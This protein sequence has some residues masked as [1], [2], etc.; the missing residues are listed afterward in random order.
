[1]SILICFYV[2][3]KGFLGVLEVVKVFGRF[4]FVYR[5]FIFEVV[6]FVVG[7]G[8]FLCIVCMEFCAFG[9]F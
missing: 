1:M 3:G 8:I 5:S 2:F 6:F 4:L 9:S 7:R